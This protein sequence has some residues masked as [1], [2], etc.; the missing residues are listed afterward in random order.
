MQRTT[1]IV[2]GLLLFGCESAPPPA[3][4][5]SV[6]A[7]TVS[8]TPI[9]NG[10][11][12]IHTKDGGRMEGE[13]VNGKRIGPWTSFFASGGIRSK[14]MYVDGLEQGATEIYHENGMVYYTGQYH[15]GKPVGEW[16]FY[17]PKGQKVRTVR[18]DSLG[19]M[20]EQH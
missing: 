11:Q 14:A 10:P 5:P 1:L 9:L 6:V 16:L 15:L 4:P 12:V 8:T 18:Y 17:D 2:T 3:P 19:T 20:L 13:L 7:D